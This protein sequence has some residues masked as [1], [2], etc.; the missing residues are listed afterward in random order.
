MSQTSTVPSAKYN[1]A[2]VEG[3]TIQL[4]AAHVEEG[5][6]AELAKVGFESLSA[7]IQ[8]KLNSAPK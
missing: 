5:K 6:V 8:G 4:R 1:N 3:R 7:D 2:N